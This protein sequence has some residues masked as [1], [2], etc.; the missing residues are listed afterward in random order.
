VNPAWFRL[1]PIGSDW[2]RLV[3]GLGEPCLV[4]T[5]VL[6]FGEP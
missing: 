1:E 5:M 3:P 6:G 4:L 2:F